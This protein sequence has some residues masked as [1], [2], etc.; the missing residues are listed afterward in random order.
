MGFSHAEH[1]DRL[2]FETISFC[3]RCVWD[4]EI[5]GRLLLI[6]VVK[7]YIDDFVSGS[8]LNS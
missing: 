5:D 6:N 2:L 3:K 8:M 7:D 1:V 4:R